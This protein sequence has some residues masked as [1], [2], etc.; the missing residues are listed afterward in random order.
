V[1]SDR[2]KRNWPTGVAGRP[3]PGARINEEPQRRVLGVNASWL[4]RSEEEPAQRV[5]G[6]PIDSFRGVDRDWLS[7]L[8]H[9]ANQ[10][11]RWIRRRR[12]GPYAP[13]D[14]AGPQG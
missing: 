10:Y 2:E 9:P 1:V 13:D 12:L 5:L 14:E 3:G 7:S 11:R 6:F 8:A 4:G